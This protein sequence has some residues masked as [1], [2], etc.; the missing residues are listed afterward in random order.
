VDRIDV[1][2]IMLILE[3]HEKELSHLHPSGH[4]HDGY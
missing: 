1:T 2:G 4:T 3:G